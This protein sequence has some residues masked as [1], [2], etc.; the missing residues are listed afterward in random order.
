[1]RK[2]LMIL[3]ATIVFV[4]SASAQGVALKNNLLYDATLT[5]NLSVEVG[6]GKKWSV[7]LGYG[8]HPFNKGREVNWRHWLVQPELRYWSCERFS[9]LFF[10]AH[11]HGGEVNMSGMSIPFILQPHS[12]MSASRYEAIFYGAGLS[13]GYQWMLS[14]RLNLELSLGGGYA[15]AHYDKYYCGEC[16][17][18]KGKD[19][20]D[21]LGITKATFSLVWLIAL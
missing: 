16:G 11:L 21:Y 18:P 15:R 17:L 5:P 2:Y 10:G 3:A 19:V 8:I 9:G 6:I 7:D 4:G 12:D 20:A 14:R 13:I 1:M